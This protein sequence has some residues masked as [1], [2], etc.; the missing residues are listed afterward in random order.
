MTT[1]EPS[2]SATRQP[3]PSQSA[4]IDSKEAVLDAA[5]KLISQYGYAGF[6]MRD[7]AQQSGLAKATL[8][9]HFADKR[10][11]FLQV[12]H[13]DLTVVRDR[14]ATAAATDGN[15]VTRLHNVA[16]AFFDLT[17]ERGMMLLSTLREASGLECEFWQLMRDY[18]DELQSPVVKL[19]SEGMAEGTIRKIDPD[20]ATT[21]F[22]GI[23]HVFTSRHLIMNDLE[24]DE[25][26][27]DFVLDFVLK[28]VQPDSSDKA[29]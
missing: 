13:R 3:A 14:L 21:S 15:C 6:S 10:E 8:Y 16:H 9:H 29:T 1:V 25:K 23:L 28:G 2:R 5:Q 22:F 19:F 18:R 7:L 26:A 20:L 11:I 24:L 12:L 27:A 17:K 4:S